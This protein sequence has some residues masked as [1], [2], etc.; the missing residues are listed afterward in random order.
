MMLK[1]LLKY[2]PQVKKM[3]QFKLDD[4]LS[5]L[6]SEFMPYDSKRRPCF[7]YNQEAGGV[8][9]DDIVFN[10]LSTDS[11]SIKPGEIFLALRGEKFDGHAYLKQ[12]AANGA[13]ML[14][15]QSDYEAFGEYLECHQEA[16]VL[17]KHELSIHKAIVGKPLDTRSKEPV[18]VA[19]DDT[20]LALQQIANG[21]RMS[22]SGKVIAITGS[23]GK[24]STREMISCCLA[25]AGRV[26]Q[27]LANLNNEIG[28]PQTL[29]ATP[30]DADFIVLE[31]GM[32]GLGQIELLS[33]IALPDISVITNI[34]WSHLELLGTRENILKA[35]TEITAGMN[36]NGLI[37]LNFD[38]EM[39]R[40]WYKSSGCKIQSANYATQRI[41]IDEPEISL[42]VE[43]ITV[44]TDK[45]SF[46]IVDDGVKLP[47]V[48]NLPGL[49][50]VSNAA[51][52]L[53]VAKSLGLNLMS[54]VTAI[55]NYRN[56]GKR[57]NIIRG[58]DICI[59][60]DTYNA[61]PESM[62]TAIKTLAVMAGCARKI[63]VLAGMLELGSYSDNAHKQV[64][65]ALVE[66][67]FK[68]ACLFGEMSNKIADGISQ[69][70][71]SLEVYQFTD[72]SKLAEFLI[73]II[74]PNDHIL[75]KGSRAYEMERVTAVLEE[76]I[77]ND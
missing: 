40:Q 65:L 53:L 54:A 42:H 36:E 71:S 48:I 57:Q 68:I 16:I 17:Y 20:L 50:H 60:D 74:E 66:E 11:R 4:I 52:G 37:V 13:A 55:A 31:M 69:A 64:G 61:A 28:L 24:T 62:L 27:T 26:H 2:W 51:A 47:A 41:Y 46:S 19:V 30:Q 8:A 59:V 15:V 32:R 12:A 25:S 56:T 29:L 72:H 38:D 14:I 63:A 21:Y 43:E 10:G 45:S 9:F 58:R 18:I 39:L 1:R 34:G 23:V 7:K 5:W 75:V 44:D 3:S 35:K 22:L 6:S 33:R 67:G 76:W 70:Q 77:K 49:H 73:S